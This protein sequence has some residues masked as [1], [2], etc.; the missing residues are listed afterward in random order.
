MSRF[1]LI[2][3]DRDLHSRVRSAAA[4][5]SGDVRTVAGHAAI[6]DPQLVLG[7]PAGVP[8]VVILGP[9]LPLDDALRLASLLSVQS[10]ATSVLLV[11]PGDADIVIQAMRSGVRGVLSPRADTGAIRAELDRAAQAFASRR[12][13]AD[14][15]GAG[16]A[17]GGRVIGVFSPK[18]GV[19]KT[20]VATNI[21]VGL[22]KVAPM[23]VVI[24]DLDLQFGD[25]ASG[26][27]LD[28]E[29]TVTHAVSGPAA[30]DSLVLKTFLTVHP[31]GI[32]ALAAPKTPAEA[33]QISASQVRQL[34]MKL[35]A[36]FQYVVVDTAPGLP[37]LN[38]A[39]M[40]ECTDAVWVSGMDVPSIRGLRSGLDT[41]RQLSILPANRHVVLNMAE[42]ATGLTVQDVEAT[43]A[44][45]VDVSIPRSRQVTLSTNRG[46]PVLQSSRADGAVKGMMRLV[47]R[48][49]PLRHAAEQR[50]SHRR[51]VVR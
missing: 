44:V 7:D 49:D 5:L 23:D 32:Y 15:A 51:E 1:V 28:P 46:V 41:L 39:A 11:A 42:S 45:P 27:F 9:E 12:R 3:P 34:L 4:G 22:G 29:H 2:S 50:R 24:V 25:V 13:S 48:F 16:T 36:Q 31:T 47:D 30:T 19:G 35:A 43:I 10:P 38:L 26:L 37:E 21:A 14:P 18:G 6:V 8:E 40:E 33:D 17:P 20:T